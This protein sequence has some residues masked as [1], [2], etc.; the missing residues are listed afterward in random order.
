[1]K[2]VRVRAGQT[3]GAQT[4]VEGEGLTEGMKVVTGLQP[5]NNAAAVATNPFTPKFPG[6]GGGAR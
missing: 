1:M 5:Q 6:R 4:E 2:P 3:D